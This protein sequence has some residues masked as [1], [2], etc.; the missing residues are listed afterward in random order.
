M[1][2]NSR[3]VHFN[4][5]T[6]MKKIME[7]IL[8][9][10]TLSATNLGNQRMKDISCVNAPSFGYRKKSWYHWDP[11]FEK[12][13]YSSTDP[14]CFEWLV[15]TSWLLLSHLKGSD[16]P[17][18][19]QLEGHCIMKASNSEKSRGQKSKLQNSFPS[20]TAKA[21]QTPSGLIF[22]SCF[23]WYYLVHYFKEHLN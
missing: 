14:H 10:L 13:S 22:W 1:P 11:F 18:Y 3:L 7:A 16:W 23:Q 21:N 19:G 5:F 2:S 9:N 8:D 15:L 17:T 20:K 6:D 4:I 12:T